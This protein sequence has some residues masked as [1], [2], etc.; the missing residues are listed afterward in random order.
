MPVREKKTHDLLLNFISRLNFG[1]SNLCF[2]QPR[3]KWQNS[4]WAMDPNNIPCW[5]LI[6]CFIPSR[7]FFG[8]K[9]T[10][11][12]ITDVIWIKYRASPGFEGRSSH[13]KSTNNIQQC[14]CGVKE[15]IRD[16]FWKEKK[17]KN[18]ITDEEFVFKTWK[19]GNVETCTA[20]IG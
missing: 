20:T 10:E 15:R 4:N 3:E 19:V 16:H 12:L 2:K 9:A 18:L 11:Y 13:A 6:S 8:P 1:R 14:V 5:P 17:E 7:D